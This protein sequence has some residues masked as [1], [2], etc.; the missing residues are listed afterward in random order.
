[1]L[2]HFDNTT[3]ASNM[4]YSESQTMGLSMTSGDDSST[5]MSI[6]R[7]ASLN[8]LTYKN[9]T[10]LARRGNNGTSPQNE[11]WEYSSIQCRYEQRFYSV[12]IRCER[13]QNTSTGAC[14]QSAQQGLILLS[15][16]VPGTELGNFAEDFV[17][18]NLPATGREATASKLSPKT[19]V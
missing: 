16:K 14:V 19:S 8:S 12:P 3:Y 17:S 18:A 5:P 15:T 4:S 9:G 1:M 7:F 2:R 11:G 10:D 6:A 13:Y